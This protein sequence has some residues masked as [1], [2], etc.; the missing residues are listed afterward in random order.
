MKIMALSEDLSQILWYTFS[1]KWKKCQTWDLEH[2]IQ[3]GYVQ[4]L[5]KNLV[6]PKSGPQIDLYDINSCRF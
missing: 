5:R 1:Q 6:N 4:K 3:M 2:H